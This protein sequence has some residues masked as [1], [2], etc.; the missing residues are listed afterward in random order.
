M[1]EPLP[2]RTRNAAATRRSILDAARNRF[3][4]DGYDHVGL[5]AISGDVGVD[6]AL[7]SRYFGSKEALFAEVVAST[8]SDPMEVL[9]GDRA[10]FGMRVARAM[11]DPARNSRQRMAF[12][13]LAT[14]STASPVASKIVRRHIEAYFIVPFANWLGGERAAETAWLTASILMGVAVMSGIACSQPES[15]EKTQDATEALARLL[16]TVID[17]S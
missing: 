13:A 10:T 7:I 5:R 8:G 9:A 15:S 2:I 16:Q 4:L 1:S 12:M 11:F 6:A 17:R 3:L 14:R